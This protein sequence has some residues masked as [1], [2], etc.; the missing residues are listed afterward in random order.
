MNVRACL[1]WLLASAVALP[2][3]AGVPPG[4]YETAAIQV[5]ITE[6]HSGDQIYTRALGPDPSRYPGESFPAVILV[7]GGTGA[8]AGAMDRP[9]LQG[10]ASEG[11]VVVAF[12]PPGRGSGSPGN[13]RSGGVED[14]NGFAGQDALKAVIEY[15][16]GLAG[17]DSD[18]LGLCTF[19]F[20]I[21]LGA[22]AV[23]RYPE[24][25]VAW[26]VDMEGPSN[27]EIVACYYCSEER[28]LGGHL[29]ITTDPSPENVAWW[30]EREAYRF[31]GSFRGNYLR[32]QA[33]NDHAQPAGLH[34]H[35]LQMNR[36]AITGG[37][38]WVR[39]NGSDMGN[40]IN[41][42]YESGE[43]AWL[44][45]R[46]A[47]YP[48]LDISYIIEMARRSGASLAPWWAADLSLPHGVDRLPG[49]TTLIT[50]GQQPSTIME[51][52]SGGRCVGLYR[53]GLTF[54][55]NADRLANGHTVVS[56]TGNNRVLELDADN[57]TVG[58]S[59]WVSLSDGSH[60]DYPD[61]VN[62][63]DGDRLLV[64]DRNNHRVI[65]IEH[66]GTI[67]WQFGQTGVAGSDASHLSSP[68]NAHR[69]ANGNTLIADSGN[70]RVVEVTPSGD[71]AWVWQPS[72]DDS[73]S[74]PRDAERLADGHTLVTDSRNGRVVEVDSAKTVVWQYANDLDLPYDADR[75]PNGDTLIADSMH[76]R[77]I[78]V[79]HAGKIVWQ[80]P[81][82][83]SP[84]RSSPFG[85]HP[86]SIR[87]P[88]YAN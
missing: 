24:L 17:V 38:P 21:A 78:E 26:L 70:D 35:A 13:L 53:G 25:P 19:S 79:S 51:V 5:W 80:Y 41:E 9:D 52:D 84:D 45:G 68:Y 18:N 11:F 85:F 14:Y 63:V 64:T 67:V 29:S 39:I 82:T 27:S 61:D 83:A 74:W 30:S 54:A 7:P 44:P 33:W 22:G 4:G 42:L 62:V 36:A 23:G 43:P 71:L 40:P 2:G 58:N 1:G 76:G 15:V 66:D 57:V 55:H 34:L 87:T 73:L 88:G 10:L 12:N 59:D 31:I 8:G 72:G 37:V 32:V 3:L 86:A 75:L 77:V 16:A 28:G 47:D 50:T 46:M 6:P 81:A 60:L 56:D 20:G 65:E 48:D 69:L 49:G